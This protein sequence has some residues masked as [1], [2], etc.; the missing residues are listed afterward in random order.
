[1]KTELKIAIVGCGGMAFGVHMP[2]IQKYISEYGG[3]TVAGCADINAER[4]KIFAEHFGVSAS[5]EDYRRMIDEVKPDVAVCL[6]SENNISAVSCE[7]L[8][9]GINTILEKPPGKTKAEV[10]AITDAAKSGGAKA[11]VAFNRRSAP[12][13]LRL[14]SLC[15]GKGMQ[16]I[17]YNFCR[18]KRHEANFEDTAIHAVD[19]AKWL[20]G[21]RYK[22]VRINYSEMPEKDNKVANYFLFCEFENSVT[23]Q[24]NILVST[25][26]IYE[27]CEIYCGDT[28]Y[29]AALSANEATFNFADDYRI[30]EYTGGVIVYKTAGFDICDDSR[31]ICYTGFYNEHKFFYDLLKSGAPIKETP[32]T[33]VQ[34]VEIC[35]AMKDRQT[36]LLW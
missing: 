19:T 30:M 10:T 21:S 11:M 15:E 33:A 13:Y 24:I 2:C 35:E 8:R 31:Y 14:R 7:V 17:V 23:A 1:M 29:T 32:E 22:S 6:V 26:N 34:S 25:G 9:R 3:V 12:I 18:I 28:V 36:I 16:H 5:F 4:A 27:G 20:S